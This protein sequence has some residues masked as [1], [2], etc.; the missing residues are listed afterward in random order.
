M[1]VPFPRSGGFSTVDKFGV[2]IDQDQGQG[3]LMQPKYQYRFRVLFF[4]FGGDGRSAESLT[5][6]TN[7][8][9]LPTLSH[10]E[11]QV[12]SY[13]SRAYFAGKHEWS[14]MTLAVRDV[15]DNSVTR[16][17][18][19]QLQ[20]Q[21]DHYNQTGFRAGAD[22]KFRMVV[23]QLDGGHDTTTENWH[24]EGCYVTNVEYGDLDYSASEMRMITMTIRP[25]NVILEGEGSG[26]ENTVFTDPGADPLST[27]INR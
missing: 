24:M 8:L 14:T 1:A 12:H 17:V 25:D 19:R 16:E 23:Q 6:N 2:S 3:P 20:R 15:Y 10:E 26:G 7:N 22:Y 18:G 4:G 27:I 21:L 9:S 11:M 5:L 13:N